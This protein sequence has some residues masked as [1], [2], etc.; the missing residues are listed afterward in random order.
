MICS[1]GCPMK[2]EGMYDKRKPEEKLWRCQRCGETK[3]EI[4]DRF[5]KKHVS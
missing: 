4:G 3:T 1:C 2:W 5:D